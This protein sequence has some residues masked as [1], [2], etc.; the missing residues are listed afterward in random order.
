[1]TKPVDLAN[2]Y[3]KSFFGQIPL[4][5][6][7]S[8]LADDLIFEGPFHKSSNAKDYLD[9]LQ[10]DPPSDVHYVIE[11]TYEDENSACLIYFVFKARGENTYGPNI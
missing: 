7:A 10:R 11:K 2:I 5:Q 3:M 6:M 9:S 1:M 4:D 8:I